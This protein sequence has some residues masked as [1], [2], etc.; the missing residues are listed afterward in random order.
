MTPHGNSRPARRRFF[1]MPPEPTPAAP[2]PFRRLLLMPWRWS[3]WI[4]V[5]ILPLMLLSY[6]L[7][8][9]PVVWLSEAGY[10]SDSAAD[11]A[12]FAYEPLS[13]A[14]EFCPPIE[15]ALAVYI[16]WWLPADPVAD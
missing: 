8:V 12:E 5:V 6:P 15:L 1:T 7:S 13:M 10:I 16:D 2:I 9:G 11:I 14:A 3:R 4:W